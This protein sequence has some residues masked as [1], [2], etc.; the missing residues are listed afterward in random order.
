MF[1]D[2]QP[3]TRHH[4]HLR[5]HIHHHLHR[6]LQ[7]LTN[8]KLSQHLSSIPSKY[9]HNNKKSPKCNRTVAKNH[10][11]F[12]CTA[13]N[14]SCKKMSFEGPDILYLKPRRGSHITKQFQTVYHPGGEVT[15]LCLAVQT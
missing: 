4:H 2:Y 3:H 11:G 15:M 5:P 6:H 12:K 1:L 8:R 7:P 10:L 13:S 14:E 9:S